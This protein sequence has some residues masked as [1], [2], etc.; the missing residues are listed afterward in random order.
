[1]D[2]LKFTRLLVVSCCLWTQLLTA[3]NHPPLCEGLSITSS[4]GRLSVTNLE[5]PIANV[6]IYDKA[7]QLLFAC[8]GDCPETIEVP[9][10]TPGLPVFLDIQ[11]F[12]EHYEAIC[13]LDAEAIIVGGDL[14]PPVVCQGDVVLKNQE[15]V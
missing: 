12:T 4:D 15:Q 1:M 13:K 14:C 5:A 6:K 8:N 9:D 3:Q 7:Y 2:K 10:L 11:L